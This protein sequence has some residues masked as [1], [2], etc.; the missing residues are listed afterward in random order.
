M[1]NY[2]LYVAVIIIV[3]VIGGMAIVAPY[4]KKKG[5]KAGTIL[6]NVEADVIKAGTIIKAAESLSPS[7][8]LNYLDIIDSLAEKAVKAAQQLYISSQLPLDQRKTKAR[9]IIL[10]G[11][12]TAK[13]ADTSEL[14]TLIDAVI[15]STILDT[16]TPE[17]QKTQEQNTLTQ[18]NT[19]LQATVTQLNTDKA[20]LEQQ[21]VDLTAKINT[22]QATVITQV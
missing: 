6:E 12:K 18:Q 5:I 17:E 3:V 9:E 13:I 10:D 8:V 14:D 7:P 20:Q 16:K 2:N 1:S 4:L 21:I 19:A 15:E 22:V 11:L